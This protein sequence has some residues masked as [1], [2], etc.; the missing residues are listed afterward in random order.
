MA[1]QCYAMVRGS[2]LRVT[3]LNR[4]G[5]PSDPVQ[6][7]VSKSVTKVTINEVVEAGSNEFIRTD[8]GEDPRLHFVQNT[9][10][11]RYGADIEFIRCDPGILS[12]VT[13]VPLTL[14]AAGDVVGFD[15][16]TK[17]PVSSF[18][19]EVWSKLAGQRCPENQRKWGYTLFPFLKGGIMTGFTFSNGLVNFTIERAKT[20][21]N[22]RWGSGPFEIEGA[23]KRMYIPVSGNTNWRTITVSGTPPTQTD[24][25]VSFSDVIDGG[26]A[27]VTT[28]DVLDGQFVV[29][30]P[31]S[32]EGGSA[33]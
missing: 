18:S 7:A 12:L 22:A 3:K 14:N 25:I 20:Q 28:A 31:D 24:G 23:G 8:D 4:F 15:A 21:R 17:L 27:A 1:T 26:T 33:A 10:I 30:S 29:T 16:N 32:I 11:I 5:D 2:V 19:L 9:E 6:Y 13:N